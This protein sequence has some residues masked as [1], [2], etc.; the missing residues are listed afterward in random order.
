MQATVK[1]SRSVCKALFLVSAILIAIATGFAAFNA[2]TRFFLDLTF[3]W[4]EELCTYC[5][6]LMVYLAIPKLEHTGDQLCIT[7]IDLWVKGEKAQ[8]I[9]NYIRG[10]IT[11]AAMVI[12]GWNGISVMLKA[13]KRHQVTYILQLPKGALYAIAMG[14]LLLAVLVWLVIMICNK[15]EFDNEPG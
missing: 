10:L 14:C 5:V 13:F 15:G 2:I 12:L 11:G 3:N 4:A 6:V 1:A 9:L 8:R 7:A